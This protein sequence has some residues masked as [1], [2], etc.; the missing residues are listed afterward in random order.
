MKDK[1]NGDGKGG[2]DGEDRRLWD[3]VTRSIKPLDGRPRKPAD[4]ETK[5]VKQSQKENKHPE[6][7]RLSAWL[8]SFGLKETV[9]PAPDE[10]FGAGIDRRTAGRLKR[11]QIPIEA[12]LDLHGMRQGEAQE[13]LTRFLSGSYDSG[14]RCVLVITGK[15]K[16]SGEGQDS[17]VLR[18][19]LPVWIGQPPL[20]G[21]I[22]L[23]SSARPQDGGA[24]A[25]YILLRRKR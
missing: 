16:A 22:L 24:G 21:M 11:G 2:L 5:P 17:G 25:F 13:A 12:R 10:P 14:R 4:S 9:S 15:G 20:A 6:K 8:P 7:P 19:M 1:N 3:F 23:H 18:R